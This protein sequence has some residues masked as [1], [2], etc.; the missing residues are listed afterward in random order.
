VR[1]GKL[2]QGLVSGGDVSEASSSMGAATATFTE[3]SSE[4]RTRTYES[5]EANRRADLSTASRSII[6]GW[7][8]EAPIDELKRRRFVDE[9]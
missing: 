7:L 8:V 9:S 1:D 2:T 3:A 4:G 5:C 6:R